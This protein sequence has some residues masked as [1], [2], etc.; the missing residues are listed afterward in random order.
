MITCGIFFSSLVPI[1]CVV[2]PCRCRILC[3]EKKCLLVCVSKRAKS[4]HMWGHLTHLFVACAVVRQSA[5]TGLS[6]SQAYFL[7]LNIWSPCLILLY[8]EKTCLILSSCWKSSQKSVDCKWIQGKI[9]PQKG[10]RDI[11]CTYNICRHPSY[12]GFYVRLPEI[13]VAL[14]SPLS[15]HV[16]RQR[17][18]ELESS[19]LEKRFST[20]RNYMPLWNYTTALSGDTAQKLFSPFACLK[21]IGRKLL[22]IFHYLFNV[23]D[24]KSKIA[25]NATILFKRLIST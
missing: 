20:D 24:F 1:S 5:T 13:P 16:F 10:L 11:E 15:A 7:A 2:L 14:C 4:R 3:F 25:M 17:S 19:L 18:I 23:H 12:F 9:G 22:I 6:L 8:L 21:E